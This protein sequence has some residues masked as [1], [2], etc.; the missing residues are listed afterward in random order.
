MDI[1]HYINLLEPAERVVRPA[2]SKGFPLGAALGLVVVST[3]ATLVWGGV[4]YARLVSILREGRDL[5]RQWVDIQDEVERL[6]A[7]RDGRDRLE[8]GVETLKGWPV[9]RYDWPALLSH[10]GDSVSDDVEPVQLTRL[11]FD[12]VIEGLR[13]QIPGKRPSDF[14]PLKR[15]V[16]LSLHGLVKSDQ[17]AEALVR[18]N[19]K[20]TETP[21]AAPPIRS[22]TLEHQY[23]LTDRERNPTDLTRF[24]FR[25]ELDLREVRP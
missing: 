7:L 18:I 11:W 3:V 25:I 6:A 13:H 1:N 24:T 9:S 19:R 8:K 14:H 12:E 22:V 21:P 20:L 10:I 23:G 5:E 2:E 15:N 4:R 17:P 16:V